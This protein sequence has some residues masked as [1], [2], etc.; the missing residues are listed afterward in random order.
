[1]RERELCVNLLMCCVAGQITVHDEEYAGL[2]FCGEEVMC[3]ELRKIC[4]DTH[5][6]LYSTMCIARR[7]GKVYATAR[8]LYK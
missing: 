5:E 6:I 7:R 4:Y 8:A 2:G 1:M 3:I